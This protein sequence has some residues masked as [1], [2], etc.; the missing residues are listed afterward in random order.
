VGDDS[1]EDDDDDR[2]E[3]EEL[4]VGRLG[5]LTAAVPPDGA[6]EVVIEVRGGPERRP[7]WSDRPLPKHAP[8]VITGV[9]PDLSLEV[10]PFPA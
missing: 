3:L 7:A 6:G 5:R 9:R 2:E 8:V 1:Y 4:F 10:A